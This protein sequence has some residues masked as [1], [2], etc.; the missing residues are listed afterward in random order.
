MCFLRRV[1]EPTIG[2]S[3]RR[4]DIWER[5]RIVPW[6]L[7]VG[8]RQL[9]CFRWLGC[10]P[11]TLQL[12]RFIHVQLGRDQGWIYNMMDWEHL[13]ILQEELG[14]VAKVKDV[15]VALLSWLSP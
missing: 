6:L 7:R 5:L 1:S 15:C 13:G 3:M 12:R 14:E 8:R 9:R 10:L 2:D 4:S 11:D